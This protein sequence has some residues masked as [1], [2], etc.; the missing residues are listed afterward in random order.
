[1]NI[2]TDPNLRSWVDSAN[3]AH[4][5]FPIQNLPFG[6]FTRRS[7]DARRIGV[8]IGDQVLD[9]HELVS[10]GLLADTCSTA[11]CAALA[12]E[13]LND[14]LGLGADTWHEVRAALCADSVDGSVSRAA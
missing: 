12:S 9:C 6:V 8:A 14:F 1:M 10:R 4:T 2:T 5:D 3:D 11:A 7:A 13:R